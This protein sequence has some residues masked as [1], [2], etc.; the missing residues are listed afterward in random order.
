[1]ASRP[2]LLLADEPTG[3]LDTRTADDIMALLERLHAEGLTIVMV[4]HDPRMGAR[5]ER[6]LGMVDGRLAS[7][8]LL[9]QVQATA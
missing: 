1:M 5:A 2:A 9:T 6:R 8:V 4:T 3:N 7:D